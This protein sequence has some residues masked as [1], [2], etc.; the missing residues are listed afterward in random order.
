MVPP[1]TQTGPSSKS[2]LKLKMESRGESI[3]WKRKADKLYS[4][5]EPKL[6]L[7]LKLSQALI[8]EDI[9][10]ARLRGLNQHHVCTTRVELDALVGDKILGAALMKKLVESELCQDTGQATKFFSKVAS[11]AV[12]L[13]YLHEILPARIIED[14]L[15]CTLESH[16][17]GTTIEAAVYHVNKVV[18]GEQA[19]EQLA[20]WL[21]YKVVVKGTEAGM[22]NNPKGLL[23]ENFG[24]TESVR[25]EGT[26][27]HA[28]EYEATAR[29]PR[30][31]NP[32]WRPD[33]PQLVKK[34]KG[35]SKK[36]AES[37]A[38]LILLKAH[39]AEITTAPPMQPKTK[40]EARMENAVGHLIT[41]GGSCVSV[42]QVNEGEVP[43][44]FVAIMQYGQQTASAS[45]STKK[46]AQRLAAQQL[47]ETAGEYNN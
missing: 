28:P 31:V 19:I 3:A 45:A 33:E 41:L 2:Q 47:L 22:I 18:G 40:F 44:L 17:A 43:P 37:K 39:Y 24:H 21:V 34:A 27:D 36:D 8:D 25:I 15:N 30:D 4:G 42:T 6:D 11:N 20:N 23:I 38:A 16:S 12:F 13:E 10:P 5:E 46:Q 9:V 7:W 1:T 35:T 14:Q 29:W 26:P 32:P